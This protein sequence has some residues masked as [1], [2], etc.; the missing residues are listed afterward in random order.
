MHILQE[1]SFKKI[2]DEVTEDIFYMSNVIF[3]NK[4]SEK[5]KME[6]VYTLLSSVSWA[7]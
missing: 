7:Q 1:I 2:Y 3:F 6:D 4:E 5:K